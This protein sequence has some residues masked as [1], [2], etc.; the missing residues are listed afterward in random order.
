MAI[1]EPGDSSNVTRRKLLASGVGAVGV[2]AAGGL[3]AACGST[4]GPGSASTGP[5]G[6]VKRG[7]NL[8]VGML[9]GGSAETL[10]VAKA[11]N[12]PDIARTAQLYD[13]LY[14]LDSQSRVVPQLISEGEPNGDGSVW[15]MRVHQGVH[16]HDGKEL[17][18]DDVL[19]TMQTWTHPSHYGYPVGVGIEVN[20]MKKVDKYTVS[21]PLKSKQARWPEQW[22]SFL[23]NLGVIPANSDSA[24]VPPGTGP[25]KFKSFTPGQRSVMPKNEDYWQQGEPFV[26]QIEVITTFSEDDARYNALLGGQIDVLPQMP[27]LQAASAESNSAVHLLRTE[28]P[29]AMCFYMRTD[30]A[31]FDDVRVRQALRL[32]VDREQL[33]E[34]VFS[35]FGKPANDLFGVGLP[36]YATDLIRTQDV[37][38]AKSL[39]NQAG[40]SDLTIT[41][42]TSQA[43]PGCAQAAP[44]LKQQAEAAGVTVNLNQV[45]S[46]EYFNSATIYLKMGLAESYLTIPGS[47][48]SSWGYLLEKS[49]P[50]N[51]THWKNSK[52]DEIVGLAN[53]E[54]DHAKAGEYWHAAQEIQ[55]DE[56]G[57]IWWGN[58]DHLDGTR[59]NVFGI[60][61]SKGAPCDYFNF[62]RTWL[63]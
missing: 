39:L 50:F 37:E 11:Y 21:V 57:Y 55:F 34:A 53:A 63:A 23:Y 29:S 4:S 31:P 49:A 24:K 12:L 9:S 35:G 45:S 42:D 19:W 10:D 20:G 15:T 28:S 6:P 44:I 43:F 17:T 59:A 58:Y 40:Q 14:T 61:A 36:F 16:F 62:R 33:V 5:S 26:D 7:G 18:A 56:G 38:N 27:Y 13:G 41:L 30:L 25:F 2:A 3:L 22:G 52:S 1:A 60:P 48:N 51:E 54:F 47:L 46:N 32:L 8:R